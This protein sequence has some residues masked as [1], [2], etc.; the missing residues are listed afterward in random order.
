MVNKNSKFSCSSLLSFEFHKRLS[1]KSKLKDKKVNIAVTY[2]EQLALMKWVQNGVIK[3]EHVLIVVNTARNTKRKKW[4][5]YQMKKLFYRNND[6]DINDQRMLR[7]VWF[8]LIIVTKKTKVWRIVGW[9]GNK[10]Y[11]FQCKYH[12]KQVAN[13]YFKNKNIIC[14]PA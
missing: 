13:S 4:S 9:N 3:L 12:F 8:F 7:W 5:S 11:C 6:G 14:L 1:L 10:K 2:H